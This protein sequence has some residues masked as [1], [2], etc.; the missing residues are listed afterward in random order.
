MGVVN[1]LAHGSVA[2]RKKDLEVGDKQVFRGHLVSVKIFAFCVGTR[3][4]VHQAGN[5]TGRHRLRPALCAH[6]PAHMCT[7]DARTESPQWREAGCGWPQQLRLRLTKTD[8]ATATADSTCE[9]QS[10]AT[11][12]QYSAIIQTPASRGR[13]HDSPSPALTRVSLWLGPSPPQAVSS[14]TS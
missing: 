11:N 6:R 5:G 3:E 10:P 9:Q 4:S 13:G 8:L 2:W 12:P 1:G 7:A 14:I